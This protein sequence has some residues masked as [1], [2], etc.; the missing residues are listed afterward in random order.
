MTPVPG[1]TVA[2]YKVGGEGQ[3]GIPFA[4]YPSMPCS[5]RPSLFK[6]AGLGRA[7]ARV[8]GDVHDAGRH[9]EVAGTTTPS[10]EIAMKLTVDKN[11]KDATEAGFD[12]TASSSGASSRSATTSARS[13]RTGSA[14]HARWP[15]TA[16]PSRSPT[17]GRHAW[18]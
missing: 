3:D 6:E 7:A 4:I 11:G 12:P 16:R 1:S 13:A 8:D 17:P 9:D 5:T 10:S 15:P 14:G 2:L 18:K